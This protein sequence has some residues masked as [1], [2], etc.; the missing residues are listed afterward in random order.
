MEAPLEIT[1]HGIDHSDALEQRIRREAM[2]LERFFKRIV[3]CHVVLERP[4]H[5]QR[6]GDLF[7]VRVHVGLPDGREINVT[8]NPDDDHAH[9]DPYVAVRDAFKAVGRLLQD[10][11]RKLGGATKH[12]ADGQTPVG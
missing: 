11:S 7:A 12:H 6:H 5:N 2:H 1:F 10:E 9:E 4:H 3:A 8:R